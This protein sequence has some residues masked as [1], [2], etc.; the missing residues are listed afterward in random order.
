M[1]H[2]KRASL[3]VAVFMTIAV[4]STAAPQGTQRGSPSTRPRVYVAP[5]SANRPLDRQLLAS[6]TNEFETALISSG[7]FDVLERRDLDRLLAQI[8]NERDLTTIRDL[9]VEATGQL[10]GR[11]ATTVV[12][13]EV[14]DDFNS[15]EII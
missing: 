10:R 9:G 7:C 6:V 4:V 1:T 14:D 3:A 8:R 5:F 11:G 12:F 13:G 15:G 2:Q